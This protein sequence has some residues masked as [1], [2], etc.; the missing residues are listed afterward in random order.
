M[1]NNYYICKH[2]TAN[3]KNITKNKRY[4][5]QEVFLCR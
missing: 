2:Q 3:L 5:E 4:G 1:E